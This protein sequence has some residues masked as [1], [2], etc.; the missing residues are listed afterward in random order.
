MYVCSYASN[1][2]LLSLNILTFFYYS[3]A[4]TVSID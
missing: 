3:I 1:V 2:E 4:L